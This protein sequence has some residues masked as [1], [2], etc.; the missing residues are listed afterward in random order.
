MCVNPVWDF[1]LQSPVLNCHCCQFVVNHHM[2]NKSKWRFQCF[3]LASQSLLPDEWLLPLL[4]SSC[5][6]WEQVWSITVTS[7]PHSFP[8][9][10]LAFE[11]HRTASTDSKCCLWFRTCFSKTCLL[12]FFFPSSGRIYKLFWPKSVLSGF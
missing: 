11:H 7:A 9:Q 10:H 2:V 6:L 1:C 3:P 5:L 8:A 12:F 4:D